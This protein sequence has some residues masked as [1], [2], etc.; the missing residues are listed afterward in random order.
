MKMTKEHYDVLKKKVEA[1]LP[2]IENQRTRI[3]LDRKVKDPGKRL[4]WDTFHAAN[5]LTAYT[6]QQFDYLDDHIET[7]M[8]SIFKELNIR[9]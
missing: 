9:L 4:L 5:I 2:G 8:K 1:L 3:S 6:Y 7:A